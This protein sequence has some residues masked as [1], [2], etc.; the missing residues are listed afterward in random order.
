MAKRKS[1]ARKSSAA[2]RKLVIDS[3]LTEIAKGYAW[4]LGV[5]ADA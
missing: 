1:H 4:A 3:K 2:K 5:M